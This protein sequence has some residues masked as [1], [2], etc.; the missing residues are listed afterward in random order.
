M[1]DVCGGVSPDPWCSGQVVK[2]PGCA[3]SG[4]SLHLSLAVRER[5][6]SI[7]VKV[8]RRRAVTFKRRGDRQTT[9]RFRLGSARNPRLRVGLTERI[10]VGRYRETITYSRVYDV[11]GGTSKRH[12]SSGPPTGSPYGS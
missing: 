12:K 11:C 5:F 1:P 8:G 10:R 2:V 7:S 3:A 6:V 9:V 4:I